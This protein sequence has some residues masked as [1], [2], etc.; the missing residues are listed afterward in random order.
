M[1]LFTDAIYSPVYLTTVILTGIPGYCKD[2]RWVYME[3]SQGGKKIYLR[4]Y[5]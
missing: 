5:T 3:I 1:Q 4:K 2:G